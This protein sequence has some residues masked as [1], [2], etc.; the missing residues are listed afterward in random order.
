[1]NDRE[2][3]R[4]LLDSHTQLAALLEHL[5]AL[6]QRIHDSEGTGYP[7]STR[8]DAQRTTGPATVLHC[9]THGEDNC[10]CGQNTPIPVASDRAGDAAVAV[11]DAALK[12]L[13]DLDERITT[14]AKTVEDLHAIRGD[15][16][17]TS[18]Q[19]DRLMHPDLDDPDSTYCEVVD[20]VRDKHG[21]P[22]RREPMH[23]FSD[24]GG[25]LPIRMR[26]G[27]WAYDF[28]RDTG[29]LPTMPQIEAHVNGE[30]VMKKVS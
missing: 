25:V 3:F 26:L 18:V 30:R 11:A 13:S 17:L 21:V 4:S 12:A 20:R 6:L 8:M 7:R 29:D 5:P 14:L 2:R 9:F 22:V 24:V 1:M 15:Y 27:R 16:I 19:Q 10:T 28:V 23:R